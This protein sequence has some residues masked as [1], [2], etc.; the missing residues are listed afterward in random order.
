MFSFIDNIPH[1]FSVSGENVLK[2][3]CIFKDNLF[4]VFLIWK[5]I[6]CSPFWDKISLKLYLILIE[7]FCRTYFCSL[8]FLE[9]DFF[10]LPSCKKHG[11][12]NV[13]YQEEI[14]IEILYVQQFKI[15]FFSVIYLMRSMSLTKRNEIILWLISD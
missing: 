6:R 12:K 7:R 1:T 3:L 2:S 10:F 11:E 8:W 13:C 4:D 5:E 15:M 9:K 14:D